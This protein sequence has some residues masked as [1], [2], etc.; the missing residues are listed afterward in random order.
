MDHIEGDDK[1][2]VTQ[3]S[4]KVLQITKGISTYTLHL[5][6]MEKAIE[7]KIK[8]K[9]SPSTYEGIFTLEEFLKLHKLFYIFDS[10]EDI[11]SVVKDKINSNKFEISEDDNIFALVL[12]FDLDIRKQKVILKIPKNPEMNV[13]LILDDMANTIIAL[14]QRIKTLE[15]KQKSYM[16]GSSIVTTDNVE[17]IKKW[18][19]D[20]GAYDVSF[21]LLYKASAHGDRAADFHA[22]C[23]NQGPTIAFIETLAG[24]KFG[25]FTSLNWDKSGNYKTGDATAFIFS[26]DH[27]MKFPITSP[28]NNVIYCQASYN[29]T[30]GGGHDF[31]ICDYIGNTG[32]Y[33]NFPS[34]YNGENLQNNPKTYLAGTYHFTAREVEVY[35]VKKN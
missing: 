9:L 26:I 24:R 35:S 19:D 15:E 23:D 34:S 33:C 8:K 10:L 7:F 29:V 17:I 4:D 1:I 21:T 11:F 28:N 20:S 5:N 27:K 3:L 22:K 13:G 16:E 14:E 25:G 18:I 6:L 32:S 30:F 31:Y 2:I 12:I